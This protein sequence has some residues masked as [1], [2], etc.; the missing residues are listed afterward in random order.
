[1]LQKIVAVEMDEITQMVDYTNTLITRQMKAL[2][3]CEPLHGPN[4]GDCLW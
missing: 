3:K 4:L 2:T 1:M